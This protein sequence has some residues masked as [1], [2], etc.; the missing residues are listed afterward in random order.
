MTRKISKGRGE[1]KWKLEMRERERGVD[2][3][4]FVD[5]K[6]RKGEGGGGSGRGRYIGNSSLPTA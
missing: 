2:S 1:E 5:S 3:C 4:K 6:R